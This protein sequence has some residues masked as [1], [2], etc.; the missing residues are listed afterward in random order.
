MIDGRGRVLIVDDS[1]VN[2]LVLQRTLEAEGLET[3]VAHD[4][5]GALAALREPGVAFDVVLLDLVMPNMDG[6]ETL[7]RLKADPKLQHLPVIVITAVDEVASVARCIEMGAAD[8]L[9]KPF[10][11]AILRARISASLASKRLRDLELEYLEQV[12]QVTDAAV[13]L[14]SGDFDPGTLDGVADREDA[15]GRLARVFQ[16]MAVEVQARERR[17]QQQVQELRIEIDEARQ[18]KQLQEITGTDYFRQLREDAGN[19]RRLL[20]T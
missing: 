2:R 17:M 11:A 4:G 19:L 8:Y 10:N 13:A 16:G 1:P 9:P 14:E 6:Y 5:L 3:G 18:G 12:D 20:E 15:L 7:S